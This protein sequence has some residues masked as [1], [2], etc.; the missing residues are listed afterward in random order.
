V[1]A[2]G[3]TLFSPIGNCLESIQADAAILTDV[4]AELGQIH[5]SASTLKIPLAANHTTATLIDA[6]GRVD[7]DRWATLR[8]TILQRMPGDLES[9]LG[10]CYTLGA[11]AWTV[12]T[13]SDGLADR[14][15]DDFVTKLWA[16]RNAT[17]PKVVVRYMSSLAGGAGGPTA[18]RLANYLAEMLHEHVGAGV[19]VT[20]FQIGGLTFLGLG[21]RIFQNT[22]VGLTE[23]IA[24]T[25]DTERHSRESR[26]LVLAELPA[27]GP[28]GREIAGDRVCRSALATTLATAWFSTVVQERVQSLRSNREFGDPWGTLTAIRPA[29]YGLL[30]AEA[31]GAT[32]ALHYLSEWRELG[33]QYQSNRD[34]VG[35]TRLET[36]L[37]PGHRLR[38]VNELLEATRQANGMKPPLFDEQA[39]APPVLVGHLT[40]G[41]VCVDDYI[42]AAPDLRSLAAYRAQRVRLN[43]LKDQLEADRAHASARGLSLQGKLAVLRRGVLEAGSSLFEAAWRD[44]L[45]RY[46]VGQQAQI[47]RF[48]RAHQDYHAVAWEVAATDLKERLFTES[49]AR[50]ERA[51][52]NIDSFDERVRRTLESLAGDSAARAAPSDLELKPLADVFEDL[53]GAVKRGNVAGLR[54]LLPTRARAMTL[55]GLARL[56]GAQPTAEDVACRLRDQ[57]DYQSPY[58]GGADPKQ[59]PFLS[60][61]VL[62]PVNPELLEAMK[63]AAEQSGASQELVAADSVA[64]GASV[65]T[66]D[67]FSVKRLSDL[68]PSAYFGALKSVLNGHRNLYAISER[69]H[70]LATSVF[71]QEAQS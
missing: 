15:R 64:A 35:E 8:T 59:G 51:L 66:L 1:A 25:L 40:V 44:K 20:G 6:A 2:I 48:R 5:P 30:S 9:G 65:L 17:M 58:W 60:I 14:I 41:G 54:A 49:L 19:D 68:Y 38:G 22:A 7:A 39:T 55:P 71:E 4:P 18:G 43:S 36:A 33:S 47:R 45:E 24:Y 56:T 63:T 67:L 13:S 57:P 3:G 61:V 11:M 10:M 12:A 16:R 69:A 53:V 50:V 37:A 46:L 62:P 52:A 31:I 27:V 23:Q 28:G 29:W 42:P 21:E 70:Q 26:A 32:A 34:S